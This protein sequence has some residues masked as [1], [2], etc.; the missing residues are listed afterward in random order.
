MY[1]MAENPVPIFSGSITQIGSTNE[2]FKISR[3]KGIKTKSREIYA[4]GFYEA[5]TFLILWLKKQPDFNK[6]KCIGHR[7]VHGMNHKQAEVISASL[8][9]ELKQIRNYDP[10]HLPAEIDIIELFTRRYP[11]ILQVACFDTAFHATLPRIAKILPIP[12]RFDELGIQRYGFHGLSYAYLIE[13][14]KKKVGIA[15]ANGRIILAHLGNG[16]SLAAVKDGKSIDTSM[17]FTPAGG[18]VMGKRSGDLDPGAACYIMNSE[19]MNPKRFCHLINHESG[20]LGVSGISAD[21]RDLLQKES[22]NKGAAEAVALF[23][24]QIKK[25][26]G[27]FMAVLGGLDIVVFSGGIGENAPLIRSKICD[28]L[29]FMGIE[30]DEE[31]NEQNG[32]QIS[33]PDSKVKVLVIPTKE[34]LMIAKSATG[35]YNEFKNK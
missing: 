30:L 13:D 7:I 34:E 18:C 26:I 2:I 33:I 15:E 16:A 11:H 29:S 35:L 17:G 21:M 4:P 32:F 6:V 8:L 24:Y 25:W 22:S 3:D 19:G 14:L 1:K 9:R 28:G 23:C 5:A 20:L 31:Q 10:D 12:K 27:S